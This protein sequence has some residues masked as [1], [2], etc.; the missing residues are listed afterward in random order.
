MGT[1]LSENWPDSLEK[2]LRAYVISAV[3]ETP[4][5]YQDIFTVTTSSSAQEKDSSASGFAD[6]EEF[7][8]T[9]TYDSGSEGYDKVYTFTEYTGALKVER[10]L[11]ADNQYNIINRRASGLGEAGKRSKDKLGV[12]VFDEAF[13]T[14]PSD[15]DGC[16]LN[17]SDHPS[18]I[19]GVSNQ[20]NEGTSAFSATAV[21]ATRIL[22]RKFRG[23]QGELLSIEPDMLMVPLDQEEIG[24]EIINSKGKIDTAD[25]NQNFHYG[26]YKL[27]V[28]SRLADTKNWWMFD[29]KILKKSLFWFNREPMQFWQDK[30]SDTLLAK[31]IAYFRIGR[32]WSDWRFCFGHLVS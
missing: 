10:K 15:G 22:M 13:T 26:K 1:M 19:D 8:G 28:W 4:T 14:E 25:N 3:K 9:V 23:L 11:A 7:T 16:E 21:E 24:W 18:P 17:A 12:Q 5:M 6:F 29:S 31:Y 30:D 32:G 27:A 2:G 20:S